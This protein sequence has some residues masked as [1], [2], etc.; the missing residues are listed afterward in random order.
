MVSPSGDGGVQLSMTSLE[1]LLTSTS[2]L[3]GG[4]DTGRAD[5]II[6]EENKIW[7]YIPCTVNV[8]MRPDGLLLVTVHL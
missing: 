4:K 7:Q 5:Y 3:V 2:R 6:E 8:S 1:P